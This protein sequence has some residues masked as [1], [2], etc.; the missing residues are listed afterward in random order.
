M[1]IEIPSID[2]LKQEMLESYRREGFDEKIINAMAEVPREEFVPEQYRKYAYLEVA[3]PLGEWDS[4]IST[5]SQPWVVARMCQLLDLN[6][7]EKVLE[8]GTGSG[9]HAAVLSHLSKEVV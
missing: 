8:I 2:T 1:S 6:G 7:E 9:Y 4:Y 3:L 5:I